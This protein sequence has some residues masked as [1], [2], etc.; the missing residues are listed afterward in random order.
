MYAL[1]V[2]HS[3]DRLLVDCELIGKNI[4]N[5]LSGDA[6]QI[7]RIYFSQILCKETIQGAGLHDR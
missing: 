3:K 5:S 4:L 1:A 6:C 7:S 2:S